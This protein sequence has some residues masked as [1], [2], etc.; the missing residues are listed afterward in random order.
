MDPYPTHIRIIHRC[1]HQGHRR[2]FG[3]NLFEIGKRVLEIEYFKWKCRGIELKLMGFMYKSR[4]ICTHGCLRMKSLCSVYVFFFIGSCALFIFGF[5]KLGFGH[6]DGVDCTWVVG[7][8]L[9]GRGFWF[10]VV[11][12]GSAVGL[13]LELG[14]G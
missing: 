9:L 1:C 3:G 6:A 11:G 5:E 12:M 7:I 14:G 13:G 10:L 4:V 8:W 2:L